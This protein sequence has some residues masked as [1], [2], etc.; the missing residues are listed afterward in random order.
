M[1]PNSNVFVMQEFPLPAKRPTKGRLL[2]AAGACSLSRRSTL[3][4]LLVFVVSKEMAEAVQQV[5]HEQGEWP[6]VA[7][8]RRHVHIADN[9]SALQAVRAIA[10]WRTFPAD[11]PARH[12]E[13][14]DG[15]A[16]T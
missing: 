5:F 2:G 10:S 4:G 3:R 16:D 9:A 13:V 14:K 1:L 6:A 7:E 11:P 12:H 15:R 8:L